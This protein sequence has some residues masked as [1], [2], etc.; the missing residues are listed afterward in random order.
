LSPASLIA[1]AIVAVAVAMPTTD[2]D[3]AT[4]MTDYDADDNAATQT[5]G[6]DADDR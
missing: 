1:V 3:K 6:D 2:Y 4:Q 5:T